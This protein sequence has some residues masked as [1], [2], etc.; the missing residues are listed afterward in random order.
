M[1]QEDIA[2]E[3]NAKLRALASLENLRRQKQIEIESAR[4]LG[5]ATVAGAFLE[6]LDDVERAVDA[7][8][9]T[10]KG[11]KEEAAILAGFQHVFAKFGQVLERLEIQGFETE[12]QRFQAELMDAIAASPSNQLAPGTVATEVRRGYTRRGKL[13]RPAQV[14][15]AAEP[16][17]ED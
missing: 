2:E 8:K 10:R 5:E 13:L 9:P 3:R 15:V 7:M 11:S 14:V 1:E 17:D 12:G 4:D 6:I 16:R